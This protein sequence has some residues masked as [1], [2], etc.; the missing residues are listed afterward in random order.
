MTFLGSFKAAMAGLGIV[1]REERNFRVQCIVGLL[2][3]V[4]MFVL[5][6]HVSERIA[7]LM[8]IA[9]VLVLEILNSIVERFVDM[10]KPRLHAYARVIKDLA[11]AAVLLVSFV[12]VII[13]CII[14]IPYL[15]TFVV[16]YSHEIFS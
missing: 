16:Q 14:F 10:V 6:L 2:V 5:P 3:F 11:A 9:A 1:W 12:S 15:N 8:C 13:A 7:L 4:A